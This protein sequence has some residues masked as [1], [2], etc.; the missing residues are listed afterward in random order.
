MPT[1]GGCA[2]ARCGSASRRRAQLVAPAGRRAG[3]SRRLAACWHW[4]PAGSRCCSRSR[5]SANLALGPALAAR[6]TAMPGAF[7]VMSFDPRS[8]RWLQDQPARTSGGGWS[9]AQ[10][11]AAEALARRCGWPRRLP[12][13]RSQRRSASRGSQRVRQAHA[14]LQPGPSAPPGQRAQ[15]EVQA[16]AL[17]WEAD[18]RPRN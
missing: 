17:I 16:D 13:G 18:G 7:G 3:R 14:G 12:R 15:A 10:F 11:A 2:R 5:S 1:P 4:S 9:F 6:S 8:A